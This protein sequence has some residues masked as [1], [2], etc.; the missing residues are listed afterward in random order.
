MKYRIPA[1]GPVNVACWVF[2]GLLLLGTVSAGPPLRGAPVVS[3]STPQL[4]AV[5]SFDPFKPSTSSTS[6]STSTSSG[7]IIITDIPR[8]P[9]A[10]PVRSDHRP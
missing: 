7:T 6:S 3:T 8:A 5:A 10:P 1:H 2:G 4:A 9:H